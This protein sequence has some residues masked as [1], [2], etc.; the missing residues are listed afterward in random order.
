MLTRSNKKSKFFIYHN[1]YSQP[2][3]HVQNSFLE[4]R[5]WKFRKRGAVRQLGHFFLVILYFFYLTSLNE[6]SF[7]L[8]LESTELTL[9]SLLTTLTST[10]SSLTNTHTHARTLMSQ[11]LTLSSCV[12][13]IVSH[14]R[15]RLWHWLPARHFVLSSTPPAKCYPTGKKNTQPS[16]RQTNTPLCLTLI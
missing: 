16:K 1:H 9:L 5:Q 7:G 4:S 12:F 14:P 15:C 10:S 2:Q 8:L 3:L 11:L 6:K 13:L